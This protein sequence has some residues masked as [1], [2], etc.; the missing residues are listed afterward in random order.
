MIETKVRVEFDAEAVK[1]AVKNGGVKA[2]R[3]AGAATSVCHTMRLY[4][5]GE[6]IG[7]RLK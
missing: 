2:L 7:T 4:Q 3:S 6:Y 1:K 5:N